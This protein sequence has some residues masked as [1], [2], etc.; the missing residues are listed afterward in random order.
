M[1]DVAVSLGGLYEPSGAG[2]GATAPISGA[3]SDSDGSDTVSGAE[4]GSPGALAPAV[5]AVLGHA[6]PGSAEALRLLMQVDLPQ[7]VEAVLA[8]LA[9]EQAHAHA[10]AHAHAQA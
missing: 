6:R 8:V 10:N 7:G 2:G 5:R 9:A 1:S 3:P 4:E